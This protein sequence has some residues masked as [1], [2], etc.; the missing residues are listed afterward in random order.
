MKLTLSFNFLKQWF[1][2]WRSYLAEFLGTF[3][4]VFMA[5][6]V[7]LMDFLYGDIGTIGIALTIGFAYAAFVFVTAHISGGFLNPAVTTSLWLVQ[8]LSGVKTVF[9][10]LAQTLASFAAAGTTLA[11]FGQSALEL[12]L[13]APSMGIGVS[14]QTA[15]S[16]EAILTAVLVYGVFGTM[17]D[18]NGPV[19]FGP[20]VLGLTAVA[21]SIIA[22]PISGAALNPARAIGPLVIAKSWENLAVYIIGPLAGSLFALVYELLFLRKTPKNR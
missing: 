13:G 17:V 12:T 9:Y 15:I 22:L 11:I 8:R 20:L 14:A 19:S 18:R 1:A 5:L 6:S 3:A 4:F 7:V 16:I 21:A 2:D 10:I